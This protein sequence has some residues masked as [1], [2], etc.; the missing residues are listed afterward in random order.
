VPFY[1]GKAW[2]VNLGKAW[3]QLLDKVG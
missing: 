1:E 2:F 3:F